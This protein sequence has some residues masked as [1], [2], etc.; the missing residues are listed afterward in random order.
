EHRNVSQFILNNQAADIS[1]QD[2]IAHCANIAFDASVW[3]IWSAL[4]NGARLC[5]ITPSTLQD[6]HQF[7]DVLLREK[8]SVM[9]LTVG[10]FNE[11]LE[12]LKPV[13]GQL[14]YLLTGGDVLDPVKISRLQQSAQQPERLI[15][16]YGP[17]ETTTFVTTYT[18]DSAV[19]H[20]RSIPIGK[21]IANTQIYLLDKHGQPV[22]LGICGELYIA[23]DSVARGY[24]NRPELTAE[25]FLP[26]PFTPGQRM[27][28]T[29]D[30]GRWL[31]DGN[32]AFLGRN[33][34]QVKLRG[35]RIELGEIEASLA[36]C[37]GVRDAVV[38][39]RE[40]TPGD[41]RLVA[42][43]LAE[44]GHTPEPARLRQQLAQS[45]AEYMLPAAFV[46]LE[47]F[48]LTP[49]GK[50]DRRALPAPDRAAAVTRGNDAP[51]GEV[52]KTLAAIWCELLGLSQVG[53][54]DNFF[55]LGGHSLM[56]VQLISRIQSE[57]FIEVSISTLFLSPTLLAQAEAIFSAQLDAL[58]G[59]EIAAIQHELDEMLPEEL[60]KMI[61]E[62]HNE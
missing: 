57:F 45:L 34:F 10:L 6:P 17:T 3:E 5:V 29:G 7:R 25:R 41:K 61:S 13:F 22:P 33:D 36:A 47:S 56:A 54:H 52:E 53:R 27:Y 38:I 30:L 18:I 48:P 11:Y 16:G 26:D 44:A 28:R 60:A 50:L 51:V 4:L 62:G 9:W 46:T 8:V 55:E 21:P 58:A 2:S 20:N 24:L 37:D 12:V 23:G 1:A 32:I 49:N 43:L 19:S 31:P 40:E 35:F 59:D 14:R 39:A 42:Y 15:N